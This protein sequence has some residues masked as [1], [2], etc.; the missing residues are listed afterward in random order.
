LA[1]RWLPSEISQRRK[2]PYRAP[3]HRS[4]FGGHPPDYV[5]ELLSPEALR[6]SGWFKPAAVS[7]LVA[8][9]DLGRPLGETD[10]MALAGILSTQLLHTKFAEKFCRTTLPVAEQN[11]KVCRGSLSLQSTQ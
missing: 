5:R 9:L 4:F 6:R 11:F 2:R 10:D 1:R 3:I 7:Q 8:K